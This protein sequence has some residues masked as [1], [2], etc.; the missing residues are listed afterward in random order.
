MFRAFPHPYLGVTPNFFQPISSDI[1]IKRALKKKSF[2]FIIIFLYA[3]CAI[4]GQENYF[5]YFLFCFQ[6]NIVSHNDTT[7]P[8]M[9]F[10]NLYNFG[11]F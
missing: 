1:S 6:Q 4:F 2:G 11:N 8:A 7:V 10:G 9:N 5:F 3:V